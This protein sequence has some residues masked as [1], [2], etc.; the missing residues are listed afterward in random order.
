MSNRVILR[1]GLC[2]SQQ[3]CRI[4]TVLAKPAKAAVRGLDSGCTLWMLRTPAELSVAHS[5]LR[6]H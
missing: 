2:H 1:N 5:G 3:L 4:V 6:I